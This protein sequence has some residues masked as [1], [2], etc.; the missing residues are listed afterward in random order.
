MYQSLTFFHSVIRWFV[1][2][3]LFYSVYRAY[4]GYFS[5]RIFSKADNAIR[6]WTATIAHIQLV[7]GIILFTQSPLVKYFWSNFSA[8]VQYKEALFFG[9]IHMVLMLAA[10]VVLTIGSALS[11]RRASDREKFKTML[12]WFSVAI[13]L[14]FIAIPWPFS[15][16]AARPYFRPF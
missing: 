9:L 3:S 10:I 6:H 7:V 11:K 1:V 12:V 16:L 4:K 8:A 13:V 15:P 14:I 2:I 5:N